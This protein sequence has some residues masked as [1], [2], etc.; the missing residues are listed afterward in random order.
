MELSFPGAKVPWNFRSLERKFQGTKVC[1]NES[2]HG[3][4]VLCLEISLQG[5]K[6]QGNE[7]SI[8][9]KLLDHSV[10]RQCVLEVCGYT[11]PDPYPQVWVG[12]G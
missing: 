11:P 8:I 12:Y 7:K 5:A 2:S 1:E 6:V 4:N 10:A 9:L 3:A